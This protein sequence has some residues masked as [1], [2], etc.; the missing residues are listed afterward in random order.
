MIDHE[1]AIDRRHVRQLTDSGIDVVETLIRGLTRIVVI[2]DTKT[3]IRWGV[4]SFLVW[5]L[6]AYLSSLSILTIVTLCLHVPSSV[7]QQQG[8]GRCPSSERTDPPSGRFDPGPDDGDGRHS[9]YLCKGKSCGCQG[10]Y[11][12]NRCQKYTK[13]CFCDFK[14]ITLI[15]LLL[16]RRERRE[17]DLSVCQELAG[18]KHAHMRGD[19]P[20]EW[21]IGT[22]I[23][24]ERVSLD[25]VMVTGLLYFHFWETSII[26]YLLPTFFNF[27]LAFSLLVIILSQ[28]TTELRVYSTSVPLS[29]HSLF[30]YI[31]IRLIVG[32]NSN[33]DLFGVP[34]KQWTKVYR[35]I[36]RLVVFF[37]FFLPASMSKDNL[38]NSLGFL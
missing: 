14:R 9:R 6:S 35:T 3:S 37:F 2:E 22:F 18:L 17:C 32:Y 29:A 11:D 8:R 33:K 24:I 38:A 13:T 26:A 25:H 12:G 36:S 5:Q 23:T 27:N 15:N 21:D 1:R 10:R 4:L 28:I 34:I 31:F 30:P 7:H 20:S 19:V 16:Y